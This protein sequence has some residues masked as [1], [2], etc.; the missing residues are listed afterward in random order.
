[1]TFQQLV[2]YYYHKSRPKQQQKVMW[3]EVQYN[4]SFNTTLRIKQ[5]WSWLS[6]LVLVWHLHGLKG[7]TAETSKMGW[8][9]YVTLLPE[10]SCIDA[11]SEYTEWSNLPCASQK[12]WF[13]VFIKTGRFNDLLTWKQKYLLLWINCCNTVVQT[14]DQNF[15]G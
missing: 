5:K 2:L 15:T 6:V 4:P 11:G 14:S 3:K 10:I 1:M 7:I 9:T 13:W 8:T 12:H